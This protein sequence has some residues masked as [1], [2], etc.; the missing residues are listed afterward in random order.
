MLH[1][2]EKPLDVSYICL[3]TVICDG[4]MDRWM[5]TLIDGWTDR[6]MDG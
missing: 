2:T 5:N 4:W 1:N 3:H 6:W